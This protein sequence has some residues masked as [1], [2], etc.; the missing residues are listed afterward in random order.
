MKV[1][2]YRIVEKL[3]LD[4]MKPYFVIQHYNIIDREYH[5]HSKAPLQTLEEAQEAIRMLRRYKEPI[6]HYVE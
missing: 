3:N 4:T 1:Y 2:D 6:Y 5:L